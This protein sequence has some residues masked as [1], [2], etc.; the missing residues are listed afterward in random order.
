MQLI[1][2]IL[3]IA[4]WLNFLGAMYQTAHGGLGLGGF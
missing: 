1:L 4:R 2:E 3:S